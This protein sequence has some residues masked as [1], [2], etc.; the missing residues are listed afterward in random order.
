MKHVNCAV[1][2]DPV[3]PIN[4]DKT[5]CSITNQIDTRLLKGRLNIPLQVTLHAQT[6]LPDS[7]GYPLRPHNLINIIEDIVV[8]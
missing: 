2:T 6:A 1:Y 7:T 4:T 3:Y 8:F 5:I